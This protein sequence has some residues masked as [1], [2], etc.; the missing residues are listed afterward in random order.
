MKQILKTEFDPPHMEPLFHFFRLFNECGN[1]LDSNDPA[2][3]KLIEPETCPPPPAPHLD[4][5][6]AGR[7]AAC[8][9]NNI[10]SGEGRFSIGVNV[11]LPFLEQ[12]PLADPK[13]IRKEIGK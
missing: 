8:L 10:Q 1:I 3:D 13:R 11:R 5:N 7:Q 12:K 2:A 4:N 6:I 9:E